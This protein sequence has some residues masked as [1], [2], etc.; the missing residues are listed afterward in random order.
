MAQDIPTREEIDRVCDKLVEGITDRKLAIYPPGD[1]RKLPDDI[2]K[3]KSFVSLKKRI[4]ALRSVMNAKERNLNP[5]HRVMKPIKVNDEMIEFLKLDEEF[6]G[7]YTREL[8]VK[9]VNLY[10]SLKGLS[11]GNVVTLDARLAKAAQKEEGDQIQR[12]EIFSIVSKSIS[13]VELTQEQTD[14]LLEVL[15]REHEQLKSIADIRADIKI[16]EKQIA[17]MQDNEQAE[18]FEKEIEKNKANLVPLQERLDDIVKK[19]RFL[20]SDKKKKK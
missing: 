18:L 6:D 20:K 11:E 8:L 13:R 14:E 3:Q 2:P 9:A 7:F 15:L 10:T 5:S 1:K 17:L 4:E 19:N 12:T 16:L